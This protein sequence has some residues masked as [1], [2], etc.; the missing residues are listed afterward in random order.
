MQEMS[1]NFYT[2]LMEAGQE[3]KLSFANVPENALLL[4]HNKS[5]GREER[6]FTYE[7]GQQI[8]W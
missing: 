7:N 2:G 6:I 8:W 3:D 4:L 1:I 5:R